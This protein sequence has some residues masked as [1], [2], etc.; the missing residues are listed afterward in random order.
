MVERKFKS[1]NK[2]ALPKRRAINRLA[3]WAHFNITQSSFPSTV[4]APCTAQYY[5]AL[6]SRTSR[7]RPPNMSSPGGRLRDVVAYESFDHIGWNFVSLAYGN[8]RDLPHLLN[9]V[10]MWK[11]NFKNKKFGTSHLE[12]SVCCITQEC[13]NVTPY[14]TISALLSF[15]WSL[16][17]G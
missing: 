9:V 15:K 5:F 12:I 6:Y 17:G 8:C 10:F 1:T 13:D 2:Y 16:T 11:V 14:Y 4:R 3:L 7:K